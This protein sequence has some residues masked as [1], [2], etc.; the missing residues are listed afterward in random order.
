MENGESD[1][2]RR[3]LLC[4]VHPGGDSAPV[5][6]HRHASVDVDGHLD[7]FP[8]SR[9]MFIDAVVDDFIDEMMQSI[10]SG[11][12]DVHRRPF[13]DRIESFEDFNLIGT[14]AIRL[15]WRLFFRGH[16]LP[17]PSS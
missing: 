3:L 6:G 15:G 14:I 17:I 5:V 4:W 12:S 13:A 8:E 10:D 9:H 2:G 7:G 1:F 11:A 16:P